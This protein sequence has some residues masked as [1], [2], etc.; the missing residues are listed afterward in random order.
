[1]PDPIFFRDTDSVPPAHTPGSQ[2][3]QI[4]ESPSRSGALPT[5]AQ[6]AAP[7]LQ[8]EK[9]VIARALTTTF[10]NITQAAGILGVSRQ[11]LSYKMKKSGLKRQ[12][13]RSV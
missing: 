6:M 13:F 2:Q 10:G 4:S 9:A 3:G 8:D 5:L 11:N 7:A 1:M 12:D